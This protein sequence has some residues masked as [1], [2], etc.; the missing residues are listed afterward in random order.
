MKGIIQPLK[1]YADFNGRASRGEF[2]TFLIFVTVL[3]FAAHQIDAMRGERVAIAM[4]MGIFE[5]SITLILLLPT[6]TVGV[7]RLHD[8][9]RSGWWMMLIYLPWLATLASGDNPSLT[10][11]AAG[12]LL[13]GGI[14]WIVMMLLPGEAGENAYG[15]PPA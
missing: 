12:A 8:M 7:R 9:G 13:L 15:M 1:R 14:S 6:V 11:V 5:L 3:T 10:L 2:W 4:N